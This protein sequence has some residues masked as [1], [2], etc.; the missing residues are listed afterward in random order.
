MLLWPASL[1]D[2]IADETDRYA[3]EKGIANWRNTSTAEILTFLGITILMVSKDCP[4]SSST[5][6]EM[7]WLVSRLIFWALWRNLHV[8]GGKRPA[9]E[10][11]SNKIKPILDTLSRTFLECYSPAQELSVDESMIKYKGHVGGKVYMPRK[12]VKQGFKVWCCSCSCCGYLCTFQIYHGAPT[13]PV[14]GEKTQEK[15]LAK[16]VVGDLVA[17]FTGVNHVVYCDNFYS[18]GPLV[19]MLAG[20][21]IFFA[22]TIKKCAKGSP[23]SLKNAKPPRGTYL[24]ETVE[25]TNYFVFHDRRE[26]CFVSNVFPERMDTP[27]ARL[28]PEGV[29]T[30]CAPNSSCLQ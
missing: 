9:K 15:G 17:P 25:G 19:E 22:G 14:T 12:P 5:G 7:L 6:V 29:L 1:C 30:V 28:Q 21:Q 11:V 26:V 10:G 23:A 4:T 13:N 24:S 27:V 3:Y 8:I 2:W 16:R 18:S 20:E